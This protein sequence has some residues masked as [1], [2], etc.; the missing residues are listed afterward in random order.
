[1]VSVKI[2]FLAGTFERGKDGVGD[3]ARTLAG[4]CTRLGRESFLLSLNDAW[5]PG[6]AEAP[7]ELRL[8]ARIPWPDRVNAAKGFLA[9]I[10]PDWVSLQ[11]VPYSFHPAGLNFALPEILRA[12]IGRTPSHCMFHE[13]WIG[14]QTAAP[15]KVRIFGFCQRRIIQLMMKKL[16]CR[17][18]HT[19]NAVYVGLL[20]RHGIKATELP[21]FGSVPVV[22]NPGEI[23]RGNDSLSLGMFGSVHPQWNPDEM[24]AQLQKLGR[25]IRLTHVG[26]IGPG[27]SAWSKLIGRHKSEIELCRMGE[28][29]LENI[30]RF[31]LSF[32]FGVATTP[33]SLVGKSSSTAAM[34]DHGL[35][36][37][38]SRND[39]HFRG[40][41][42]A[43]QY[44]D[45][46]IPVD[47]KFLDR[48]AI[49]KRRP[50]KPR[51]PEIAKQFLN[52][53]SG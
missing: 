12:I 22:P 9:S 7:N 53:L 30:S 52:D 11:Y 10:R 41:S 27:E 37:I 19:S 43:M 50:P 8:G 48:L 3:Y 16:S 29:S 28:Q 34:L 20:A 35:P 31:L 14:S 42:D 47:S 23:P 26:R 38:V 5:V 49:A 36:V 21:L 25:P 4:E 33:L 32:D 40:I 45:S 15:A 13:I 51:L 1:M 39:V 44:P 17:S 18:I 2:L 24:L 6:S 46:L